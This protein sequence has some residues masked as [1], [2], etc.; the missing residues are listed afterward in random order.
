MATTE[1]VVQ[2]ARDIRDGKNLDS[3]QIA[4]VTRVTSQVGAFSRRVQA[5]IDGKGE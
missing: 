4:A 5:I 1:Q 2:Y 3:S